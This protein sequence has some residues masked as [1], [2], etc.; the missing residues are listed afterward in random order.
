MGALTLSSGF[1]YLSLTDLGSLLTF[2]HVSL[3]ICFLYAL[4]LDTTR[5]NSQIAL[6]GIQLSNLVEQSLGMRATKNS[7]FLQCPSQVQLAVFQM[8]GPHGPILN[9]SDEGNHLE[10]GMWSCAYNE[11]SQ[12]KKIKCGRP[13]EEIGI[14]RTIPFSTYIEEEA[15]SDDYSLSPGTTVPPG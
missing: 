14:P 8:G 9:G 4:Y 5:E 1:C 7:L 10:N 15:H 3:C 12:G 2:P 13:L 6:I 11:T